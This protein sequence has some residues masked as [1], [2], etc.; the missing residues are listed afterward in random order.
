MLFRS[1]NM[2]HVGEVM[3]IMTQSINEA[4]QTTKTM[5]SKYEVSAKS[6]LDIEVLSANLWRNLVLADLWVF[7]M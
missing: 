1:E 2:N 7:R 6:A 4:E 3:H 5:L